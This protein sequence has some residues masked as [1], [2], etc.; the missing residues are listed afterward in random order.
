M[1]DRFLHS[2]CSLFSFWRWLLILSYLFCLIIKLCHGSR[3]ATTV[4]S[5]AKKP[6][7]PTDEMKDFAVALDAATFNS[8]LSTAPALYAIVEFYANWLVRLPNFVV[9]KL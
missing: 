6:G 7:T 2:K 8:T 9:L 1:A 3:I 5:E 4:G